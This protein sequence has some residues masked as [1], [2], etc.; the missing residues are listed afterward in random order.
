MKEPKTCPFCGTRPHI[1]KKVSLAGNDRGAVPAHD[2][3]V[4]WDIRCP[5]CGTNKSSSGWTYYSIKNDGSV[6][7]TPQSHLSTYKGNN[8]KLEELIER[9][10]TRKG[11]EEART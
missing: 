6:V 8:D 3:E 11:E 1:V 4:S 5:T 7:I 10:N 2:I 9:W